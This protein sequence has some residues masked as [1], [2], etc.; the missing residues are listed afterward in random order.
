MVKASRTEEREGDGDAPPLELGA[1]TRRWD[2]GRTYSNGAGAAAP[3]H[4]QAINQ[5]INC[6]LHVQPG[7]YT[8][9]KNS[10]HLSITRGSLLYTS[11]SRV[12]LC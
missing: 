11:A 9:N 3:A 10:V 12:A 8:N 7:G 2:A 6:K 5:S 1:T 4:T